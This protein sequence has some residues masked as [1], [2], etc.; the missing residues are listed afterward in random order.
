MASAPRVV[1]LLSTFF[2]L[3]IFSQA[4]TPQ[5]SSA[6]ATVMAALTG[7]VLGADG[8]PLPGIHVELDDAESAMPVTS[9]YTQPDGSFELYNI[10]H[11]NY[12]VIAESANF[13][14]SDPVSLDTG[15]PNLQLRL[16]TSAS[17]LNPLDA[18]TSVARMMVPSRAQ[19]LYQRA[20]NDFNRGNYDEA[21]KQADAAL[22]I[23]QQFADALTLRGLIEV[24]K[25]NLAQGQDDLEQAIQADP[26]ESAAYVALAAVYNH[27]GRFEDAMHASEKGLS[28]APRAWQ[29]YLEMAKASIAR[30]MYQSGL[31]FLRQAE[32]LGGNTYAEVHLLKAYA[33][34]PLKLYKDAK[35]ELQ[36]SL[37]R[38]HHGEVG[39]Q[40]QEMLAQLDSLNGTGAATHP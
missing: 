16:P 13:Q 26:S 32:R 37:A 11:G 21:E 3:S 20:F 2:L 28:L 29:A 5:Q 33:L 31:K 27:N 8:R 7:K 1:A 12:E 9:T 22:E 4:Q 30:S 17:A 15:K 18:T 25:G 38:D 23:D 36:A 40:A 39:S 35:Y 10:P 24:R 34:V 19:R 6:K 14:V